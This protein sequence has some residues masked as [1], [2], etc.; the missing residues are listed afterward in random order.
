MFRWFGLA[1][2]V[3]GVGLEFKKGENRRQREGKKN[4]AGK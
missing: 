2:M 3:S 1:L 4:K